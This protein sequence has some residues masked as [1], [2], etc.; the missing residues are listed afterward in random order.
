MTDTGIGVRSSCAY[1][2]PRRSSNSQRNSSRVIKG[3]YFA[4]FDDSCLWNCAEPAPGGTI[5]IVQVVIDTN[6]LV[7]ARLSLRGASYILVEEWIEG[8]IDAAITPALFLEYEEVLK[9]PDLFTTPIEQVDALLARL[10]EVS[11]LV[12]NFPMGRPRLRDPDD[13]HV[14]DAAL[15][16]G[17]SA[18][19]TFNQADFLPAVTDFG[20]ILLTPS[21]FLKELK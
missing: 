15:G 11:R 1:S 2:E 17:A 16:S 13:E 5:R 12:K 6:I 8:H 7:S 21:E 18:I 9:R 10:V 3:A 14:L 20:L 19:V 4:N